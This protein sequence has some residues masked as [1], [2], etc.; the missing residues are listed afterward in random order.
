M[1]ETRENI[2]HLGIANSSAEI[3]PAGTVVLSR[4]APAG[5][6]AIMGRD[7]ATSQDFV[8]WTCGPLLRPRFLLLCLRAMRKD[9]L[10]RLAQGST[11][12]TIYMPDLESIQIPLPPVAEQDEIVEAVWRR[13]ATIVGATDLLARQLDLLAEHRQALITAAVTGE[14][15]VPNAA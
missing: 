15:E 10:E 2:S 8:T 6:S 9:L 4:T 3:H 11:H 14:M 7:M 5:Y 12:Q 13:L 1:T